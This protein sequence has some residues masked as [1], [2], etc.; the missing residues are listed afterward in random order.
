MS[1]IEYFIERN[2]VTKEEFDAFHAQ[3]GES[4]FLGCAKLPGGGKSTSKAVH[5]VD[6]KW[7]FVIKSTKNG[8]HKHK[9]KLASD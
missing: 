8:C 9:I 7:Y 2:Q 6:N 5:K 3:L 4:N 1:D